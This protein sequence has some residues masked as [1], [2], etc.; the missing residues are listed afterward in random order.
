MHD[1]QIGI[2]EPLTRHFL[3]YYSLLT[4]PCT[5]NLPKPDDTTPFA[6]GKYSNQR[7]VRFLGK[8]C[9]AL[10]FSTLI[11]CNAANPSLG[12][13]QVIPVTLPAGPSNQKSQIIL[14]A[15]FD[16][17]NHHDLPGVLATL[18]DVNYG[19]CDYANGVF[20][21][22]H[23][24]DDLATWLKARFADQDRLEIREMYIGAADGYPPND[25]T[26][27]GVDVRRTSNTLQA[28]GTTK[29]LGIKII[30]TKD[31]DKIGA[32]AIEGNVSCTRA[33]QNG[34]E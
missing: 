21:S 24:K 9:C 12:S 15:F 5:M 18:G 6:I 14:Q 25:P 26:S 29:R 4:K 19:D 31:G 8:L 2:E 33:G 17:Y 28:I 30:L 27:T 1:F 22:I 13:N 11:A 7:M 34:A 16:A 20:H 32:V 3:T 23:T 10:L